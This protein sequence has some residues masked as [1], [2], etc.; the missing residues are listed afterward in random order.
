MPLSCICGTVLSFLL[1]NN[2]KINTSKEVSS[3]ICENPL[4]LMDYCATITVKKIKKR[5]DYGK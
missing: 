4:K 2:G 1:Y 3:H 5:Q